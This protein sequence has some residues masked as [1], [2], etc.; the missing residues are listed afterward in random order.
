L[1]RIEA[2]AKAAA[3]SPGAGFFLIRFWIAVA[4]LRTADQSSAGVSAL[5]LCGFLAPP[6]PLMKL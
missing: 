1:T 3:T 2:R 5:E 4:S 6:D